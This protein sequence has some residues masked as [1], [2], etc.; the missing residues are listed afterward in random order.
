MKAE[1]AGKVALVTGAGSGIGRASAQLFAE[2]GAR[3]VVADIDRDMGLETV[4]MILS[5]GGE[6]SFVTVDAASEASIRDMVDHAIAT[7]GRLDAAH[8]H[9]GHGGPLGAVTD[10]SL[11]DFEQCLRLNTIS[12]FLGMKYEIPRMLESGGGAI[13]NTGSVASLIGTP[14]MSAYV[15]AKHGVAGLTKTTALD[16][17][18]R[19]IRVNALCPGATDTPMMQGAL[20]HLQGAAPELIRDWVEPVGRFGTAR[21]QAEAAVWLCSSAASFVTGHIFP[22]DGGHLAGNRPPH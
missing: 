22:V 12:C 20:Q 9:V 1:F 16:F 19:N 2:R 8:N 3:V 18:T 6:G 14:A 13:V 21:E 5:A 11:A 4:D 17:A 15:S 10:I 7:Y